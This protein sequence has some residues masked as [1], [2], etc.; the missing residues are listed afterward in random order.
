[1]F[2]RVVRASFAQRRKTL[3]NG[4]ES[5]FGGVLTKDA[6]R[7]AVVA[8][9]HDASIRGETLDVAGFA[10]LAEELKARLNRRPEGGGA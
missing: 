10:R 4:L 6:L 5:A 8:C 7:D 9:G 2:F 3:V 1:M